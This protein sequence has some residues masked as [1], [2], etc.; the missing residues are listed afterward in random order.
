MARNPPPDYAPPAIPN[1]IVVRQ[2][3]GCLLQLIWFFFVGWWLGL[4]AIAFAYVM[5]LLIITIPIGVLVLNALPELIALR[6]A[7]RRVTV[8]GPVQ[9]PQLSI[10]V[11]SL[12]FLLVGWW[13][14][15]VVLMLGYVLCL[16][17]IGIPLGFVLF[18][19]A[20]AALT[21]RRA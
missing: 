6:P 1:A 9:T 21:L 10:F 11:R 12:W 13:L 18:D 14:T 15:A 20:P 8:Y 3:P 2:R 5:F 16:T 4:A 19:A 7:A 17:L